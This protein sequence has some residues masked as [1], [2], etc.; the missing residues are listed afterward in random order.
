MDKEERKIAD[1]NREIYRPV[2]DSCGRLVGK[3]HSKKCKY[4]VGNFRRRVA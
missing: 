2:C 1:I 4:F 3:G